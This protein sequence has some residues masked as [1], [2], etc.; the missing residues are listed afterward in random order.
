MKHMKKIV[1]VVLSLVLV[2][3]AA[4]VSAGAVDDV[5]EMT[6]TGADEASV[7]YYLG[8]SNLDGAVSI[9]DA[10]HIQRYLAAYS[11]PSFKSENLSDTNRSGEVDILDA[12]QIQRYLVGYP[13]AQGIDAAVAPRTMTFSSGYAQPFVEIN[14]ISEGYRNTGS[15]IVRIVVYVETDYDTDLDGK[16]DL[17]KAWV[18]IPRAAAEGDYKAPVVFEA[19]PYSTNHDS[20]DYPDGEVGIHESAFM[21]TP[22][23]RTPNGITTTEQLAADF[24]YK[25][26]KDYSSGDYSHYYYYLSRGYALVGSAGLGTRGSEGLELCGSVMECDAFKSIV[27]WIH[28]DRRAYTNLTDNIEIKAD[29]TNGKTGMLG[30]SYMGT[31]AYEVAATGVEGLE[32]IVPS[33]GISSWYDYINRQG[34]PQYGF[35]DYN[36]FLSGLCASRFFDGIDDEDAYNYYL[37]WRK[38]IREAQTALKSNYGESWDVRDFSQVSNIKAAALIVQGLNDDNVRPKHFKLMMEA[39]E[40]SGATAKALLH[41]GGH[42]SLSNGDWTMKLGSYENYNWLVDRWFAHYLMGV[43]NKAESIPKYI[44]ESSTDGNFYTYDEWESGDSFVFDLNEGTGDRVIYRGATYTW[45]KYIDDPTTIKGVVEVHLRMKTD[46]LDFGKTAVK[47]SLIDSASSGFYYYGGSMTTYIT[48]WTNMYADRDAAIYRHNSNYGNNWT[49]TD[50]QIDLCTPDAGW[51]PQTA[52][53][54][55]QPVQEGEWH[56]YVIYLEPEVYTLRAGHYLDVRLQALFENPN[57]DYWSDASVTID[58]SASYVVIPTDQES[59]RPYFR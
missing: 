49:F 50:G 51:E 59:T 39:F 10:T 1:S 48:A 30:H 38:Y 42:D 11:L 13:S 46:N 57:G 18:Q 29:W 5:D 56:D 47:A 40:R 9:L 37:A 3:S 34:S 4:A 25:D 41:Q 15:D 33:A 35:Y 27:E 45:S 20:I 31:L 28:G 32:A 14:E 44:V 54:P 53:A 2:M 6:Y 17:V 23:K 19:N 21:T 55:A 16:P 22:A 24:R 52:V 8:D 12:T 43:N 58:Q 26:I 7:T 36:V